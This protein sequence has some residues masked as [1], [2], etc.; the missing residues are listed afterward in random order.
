MADAHVTLAAQHPSAV[1]N[2][3]VTVSGLATGETLSGTP[4][5]TPQSG[6]T[7]AASPAPA[8]T[9]AASNTVT[10]TLSGGVSGRKYE[11]EIR[12]GTSNSNTVVI[13]WDILIYDRA[14]NA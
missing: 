7:V 13:T 2:H 14:P 9:G 5:V 4:T 12:C 8:V 11:G 1:L 10:F 6:L 3:A